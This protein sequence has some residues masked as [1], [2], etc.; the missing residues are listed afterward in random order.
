M[1]EGIEY[2]ASDR[3]V[4]AKLF[5]AH[6]TNMEGALC[7]ALIAGFEALA[8]RPDELPTCA[9]L[10]RE[11]RRTTGWATEPV[12]GLI[13]VDAFFG[14]LSRR[15]FP[16][17]L[18]VRSSDALGFSMVPD[19]FHEVGHCAMLM[20]SSFAE[21]AQGLG[22]LAMRYQSSEAGALC[23]KLYWFTAEVGLLADEAGPRALGANFL[24]SQSERENLRSGAAEVR[25]LDIAE[26]DAHE[27]DIFRLQ[28]RYYLFD[29]IE[30]LAGT[31][32][33]ALER[34][35]VRREERCA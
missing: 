6:V 10:S 13:P 25:R 35:L 4:W 17:N 20:N 29:D 33:P 15:Q 34:D 23:E 24:S 26:L 14:M 28:P 1:G 9:Q 30:Q 11:L 5:E 2:S 19:L 32:L 18:H 21:F 7:P 8:L 22:Q 3:R 12:A 31:W 27:L 16:I